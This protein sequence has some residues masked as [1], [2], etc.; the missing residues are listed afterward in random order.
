MEK[1]KIKKITLISILV[2]IL[3]IISVFYLKN[4]LPMKYISNINSNYDTRQ[5]K[6]VAEY[7][8]KL[9]S[10]KEYLGD[11]NDEYKLIKYKVQYSSAMSLFEQGEY[12]KALTN[13]QKIE[14]I[15]ENIQNAINDCKYE[16]VKKYIDEAKYNDALELLK[17]VTNKEDILDLEDKIHYNL[18]FE[19][20][21]EKDY[22]NALEEISKVQNKNYE[23]LENAIK[24]IHYEY[25]KWFLEQRDYNSAI[26]QLQEA[27]EFED[28]N[29]LINNSYI[30][31][32]EN[33]LKD[34]NAKEAKEIYNQ[35]LD[36]F[37]YNGIK[38]LDRKNQLNKFA[39]LIDATGKKYATK[40]YC[41]SRN[42]WKY[43]GRYEYW[44]LDKADTREYIDTAL[45]L[46]DDG[47]VTI[48]GTV[49]FYAFDNFSSL[50]RY[51][52]AK[53]VSRNIK[54]YNITSIPSTYDLDSNTKLLYSNGTFSIKYSKKDDYSTNFYN[55]YTSSV[56]Y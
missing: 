1:K 50:Q 46:N 16:L 52:N 54:M 12:Y 37:E 29:T 20:L 25:G 13:L 43:D 14:P 10:I 53:I 47:T 11:N 6:K 48:S 24:Q 40:S 36:N 32:A 2:I 17:D 41:E 39:K 51:C 3:L 15:D 7:N 26:S 22:K 42:V 45:T 31:Q 49:Y 4:I 8:S 35:L 34:G 55:L 5:Y 56:T 27:N 21:N 33:Y 44:Y 18:A 38:V 19:N 9:E 30:E 23:N 28:A